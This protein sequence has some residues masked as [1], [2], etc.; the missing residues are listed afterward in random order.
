MMAHFED[1]RRD[2]RVVGTVPQVDL[3]DVA[4]AMRSLSTETAGVGPQSPLQRLVSVAVERVPGTRWA[5]VSLLRAGR[6]TT[7]AATDDIAVRADTMQY[8]IGS[9]P[10]VDAALDDSVYVTG[11]VTSGE[12]WATWGHRVATELGVRSVF[13]Q[14]LHLIEG[15][16]FIASLNIYSD[17]PAAFDDHAV[18]M[19]LVL[20]THAAM[21]VSE[22][23]ARDRADNLRRAL[24]SNRE[25]GVAI[26]VLMHQHRI[27]REQA[28]D[29]LRVA[30]QDSNRKLADVA[31]DVADTGVLTIRR[32]AGT[33]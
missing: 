28:F 5:S 31:A 12:R 25:I 23:I 1:E 11:D 27:T 20:A 8:D 26:G 4:V 22:T 33:T 9:G 32:R 10:C 13:A 30:S 6:F 15:S 16:D 18:G 24:E 29:L 7:P 21:I 3:R 14:R 17:Q 2:G 19:G